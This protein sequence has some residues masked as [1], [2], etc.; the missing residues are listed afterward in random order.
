MGGFTSAPPLLAARRLGAWT[1]LHE[2]NTV[3]GRANRWLARAVDQVFVGFPQAA[4]RLPHRNLLITGTPVRRQFQPRDAYPCRVAVGLDPARPVLLVMGGSQ[5][6]S[7]I[8]DLVIQALPHLRQSAPDLQL[9][10]LAGP[11]DVG[12]VET[13][14][15]ALK[16]KAVVHSFFKAVE[17]AL[18]AATV[19]ISRA[20]SSSLAEIAA[21]RVPSVLIPYPAATHNHQFHNARAIQESGA[22]CLL[23]QQSATPE[24]LTRVVSE[25]LANQPVREKMQAALARWHTP[26]AAGQL[27]EEILRSAGVDPDVIEDGGELPGQGSLPSGVEEP[28][29]VS[30]A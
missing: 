16:F 23:E 26:H 25:L 15:R 10:H 24:S 2:S 13:A 18:G 3:P 14:C 5:G 19:A 27:A 11:A 28:G 8:N 20:G 12:K 6:A 17:L 22:A 4:A 29:N 30:P 9:L 7:G 1:F 21:M